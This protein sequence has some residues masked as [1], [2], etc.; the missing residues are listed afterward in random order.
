MC[1]NAFF[2]VQ[3]HSEIWCFF[4]F[5]SRFSISRPPKKHEWRQSAASVCVIRIAMGACCL[6]Q[7]PMN[8]SRF[9]ALKIASHP[10]RPKNLA[11][12]SRNL[13]HIAEIF[14]EGLLEANAAAN[15]EQQSGIRTFNKRV[16][17][18]AS[19]SSKYCD[20][21]KIEI[22]SCCR[23][24]PEW[25]TLRGFWCSLKLLN[26]TL[27]TNRKASNYLLQVRFLRWSHS[28]VFKNWYA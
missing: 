19:D 1:E 3:K 27:P 28:T 16:E 15:R 6:L 17:G 9:T 23:C 24:L 20:K 10:K 5:C 2:S 14:W 26:N 4:T 12:S 7:Y 11:Q 13:W 8:S 22:W 21:A 25:S 18:A